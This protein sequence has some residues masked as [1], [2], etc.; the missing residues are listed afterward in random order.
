MAYLKFVNDLVP[1]KGSV[2]KMS[3]HVIKVTTETS[4]SPNSSGFRA[5][6]DYEMKKL[7]GDWRSFNHI[8]PQ[9]GDR[10][11]WYLSDDGSTPQ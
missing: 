6:R 11:T 1:Y 7:L 2:V 10:N 8:Y 5:Y 4:I 3:E 9:V